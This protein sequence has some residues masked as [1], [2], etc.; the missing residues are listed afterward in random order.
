MWKSMIYVSWR[1]V[2]RNILYYIIYIL[3]TSASCETVFHVYNNNN[4]IWIKITIKCVVVR[5]IHM[6]LYCVEW[7]SKANTINYSSR[8]WLYLWS[9]LNISFATITLM[10]LSFTALPWRLYLTTV[11]Y[12]IR[13]VQL[14]K[15]WLF[16]C[17]LELPA[18]KRLGLDQTSHCISTL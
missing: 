13:L 6:C 11:N 12:V 1:E 14:V 16:F 3:I 9:S 2:H 15:V 8:H 18:S 10:G 5:D 4:I 7:M 17:L